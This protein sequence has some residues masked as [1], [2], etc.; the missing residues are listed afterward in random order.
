MENKRIILV[1][2]DFSDVCLNAIHYG[3]KLAGLLNYSL[4]IL[5]VINNKTKS[6]L[7][8][9]KL[10]FANVTK[11]LDALTKKTA[12]KHNTRVIHFA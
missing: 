2:T 6:E 1:P 5:H 9:E 3:A 4:I 11:K 8:K 10:T 7:K 12:T